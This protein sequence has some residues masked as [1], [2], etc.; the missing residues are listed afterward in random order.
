MP[1]PFDE[2]P[3]DDDWE[4]HRR[5][6]IGLGENS[7]RKTYYPELRRNVANVKNLVLA[8]EQS[9]RGIFIAVRS[10]HIEYAN[11]M[12]LTLT[13][14]ASGELVG[15]TAEILWALVRKGAGYAV[16]EEQMVAGLPWSGDLFLTSGSGERR[17][18]F[19]SIVPVHDDTG[20]IT[21]FLGSM[22]DISA[23]KQADE[24]LQAIAQA[25]AQALEA[26]EHLSALKSEFIANMSHELRTPIFQILGL[27]RLGGRTQDIERARS[28]A[29]KV[30]EAGERLLKI[31]DTVLDFSAVESGRLVLNPALCSV[32]KL[33]DEVAGKWTSRIADKGLYFEVERNTEPDLETAV[34][35]K[36]VHQV[37]DKLLSNALKFTEHGLIQFSVGT[38]DR[39]IEFSVTDS[40]AGMTEAQ[41]HKGLLPF[42][43]IDGSAT[44]RIGGMGLG[45]TLVRQLV[46]LMGGQLAAESTPGVGSRFQ[47]SLPMA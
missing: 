14:M 40:G 7:F 28:H 35:G 44:R 25:R 42:Q 43:Q 8:V 24:E 2:A 13:G 18:V 31:V 12:L 11:G 1:K 39:A 4:A 9:P 23:R 20:D 16:V 5:Q 30:G 21:H 46:A 33:I 34:D 41:L 47:I 15:K 32:T 10:G 19:V 17:W 3:P 45:L 36:R 6:V 38:N 22:E 27:A 26:A 29:Q 37:L